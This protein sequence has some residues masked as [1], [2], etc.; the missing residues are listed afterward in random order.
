MLANIHLL[1]L[2]MQIGVPAAMIDRRNKLYLKKESFTIKKA[3]Q[4]G[5]YVSLLPFT[6]KV[7][8]LTLGGF[9]YPLDHITMTSGISLGVSNEITREEAYVEFSE[10]ILLVVES[11]D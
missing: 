4:H 5:E 8:G 6:E 3:S 9:K 11:K 2:P 10:G 7:S 1:L